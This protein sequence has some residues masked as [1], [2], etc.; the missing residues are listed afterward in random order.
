MSICLSHTECNAIC[1]KSTRNQHTDEISHRSPA[2]KIVY[3]LFNFLS[4]LSWYTRRR[5]PLWRR[6][7]TPTQINSRFQL[8]FCLSHAHAPKRNM[9]IQGAKKRVCKISMGFAEIGRKH[10]VI[11]TFSCEKLQSNSRSNLRFLFLPIDE[12]SN[13][14]NVWRQSVTNVTAW[15]SND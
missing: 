11:M 13:E 6:L 15:L 5:W 12:I 14:K 9:T 10:T 1:A 2:V 4:F 7:L 8:A 3:I